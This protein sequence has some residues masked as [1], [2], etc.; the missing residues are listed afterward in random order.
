MCLYVCVYMCNHVC[1]YREKPEVDLSLF[2]I[3]FSTLPLETGSLTVS[4]AYWPGWAGW[5]FEPQISSCP[6][7]YI[8]GIQ[9]YTTMPGF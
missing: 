8:D 4:G 5:S 2:L 3:C 9:V 6:C 1:V 7:F